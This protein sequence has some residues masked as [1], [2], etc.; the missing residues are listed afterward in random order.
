MKYLLSAS[1]LTLMLL[2]SGCGDDQPPEPEVQI[3]PGSDTNVTD[4]DPEE[5]EEALE[6]QEEAREEAN[7]ETEEN[8]ETDRTDPYA[9]FLDDGA[10]AHFE[11]EG[12]E[13]AQLRVETNHMEADHIALYED[14]GG[15]TILRVYRLG[16]DRIE[17]VKEEPEFYEEYSATAEELQELEPISTYLE[18][19]LEEGNEIGDRT[20]IETGATVETPY[21]TFEE[22]YVL[23]SVSEDGAINTSYFVEG[24]GEVKREFYME[25]EE[26]DSFMVTSSLESIE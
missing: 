21:E 4:T 16:A 24:Y 6:E 22:A 2:V 18:F 12:I 9:F 15:T 3:P 23:E 7:E 13:F 10:I 26:Q 1:G 14:N 5:A 11:G 19:P 8:D 25:E 20:V 17:L